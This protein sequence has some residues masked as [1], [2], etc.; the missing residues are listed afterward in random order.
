M[1]TLIRIGLT[2][3]LLVMVY[4]ETGIYTT[5][6]LSLSSIGYEMTAFNNA[7]KKPKNDSDLIKSSNWR[8]KI[9][10]MQLKN[11]KK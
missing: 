11:K 2:I 1:T 7:K 8:E 5:I 4:F 9:A 6:L 3:F 10:E